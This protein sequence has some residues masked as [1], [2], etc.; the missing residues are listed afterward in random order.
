MS[1]PQLRGLS[2][3]VKPIRLRQQR[4]KTKNCIVKFY[5]N[6]YRSKQFR[7]VQLAATRTSTQIALNLLRQLETG[8]NYG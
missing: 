6:L 1:I 2:I 3:V 8:L 4:T 7:I 5:S